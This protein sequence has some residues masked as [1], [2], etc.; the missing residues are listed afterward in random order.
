MFNNTIKKRLMALF[1]SDTERQN[2]DVKKRVEM[3]SF[4]GRDSDNEM[5]SMHHNMNDKK[6]N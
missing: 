2:K 4:C 3:K 6:F 5:S 1:F